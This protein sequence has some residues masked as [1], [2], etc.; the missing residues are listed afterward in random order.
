MFTFD[1]EGI[2]LIHLVSFFLQYTFRCFTVLITF[3]FEFQLKTEFFY[4]IRFFFLSSVQHFILNLY[5]RL[6]CFILF[7]FFLSDHGKI[8]FIH[9]IPS[10]LQYN[11]SF[12]FQPKPV[13]FIL[14]Q[15]FFTFTSDLGKTFSFSFAVFPYVAIPTAIPFWFFPTFGF[16]LRWII[17]LHLI[18][19]LLS[20]FWLRYYSICI[21]FVTLQFP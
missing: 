3:N 1:L 4:P 8:I 7:R 18:P 9:W 10:F 6:H 20:F 2:I 19:L 14:L 17:L 12:W 5:Q 16:D 11:V 13:F 21:L 15:F